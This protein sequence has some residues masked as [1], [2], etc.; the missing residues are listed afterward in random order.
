MMNT[1]N[2]AGIDLVYGRDDEPDMTQKSSL[3]KFDLQ[4]HKRM[5]QWVDDL[6]QSLPYL[7]LRL[8]TAGAY[9][10]KPGYHGK[11]RAF[12]LDGIVME[13]AEG[14]V[15]WQAT[16]YAKPNYRA[17]YLGIQASCLRHFGTVLAWEYN[18]AHHDHI[19]MDDGRDVGFRKSTS[20]VSFLQ[21][22]SMYVYDHPVEIDGIW[23]SE[24]VTAVANMNASGVESSSADQWRH[25]LKY[26][27]MLKAFKT[28]PY[29]PKYNFSRG[30]ER[31]GTEPDRELPP[32][33][34][35]IR[36]V[37]LDELGKIEKSIAR[38]KELWSH[39]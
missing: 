7:M 18:E 9:V 23:G 31:P 13:T 37:L 25:W 33:T 26:S 10:D 17:F 14:A 22:V 21:A 35:P 28:L 6:H 20:I 4:F 3:F 1:R 12:D 8:V 16:D 11:G 5:G 19:H 36:A 29:G 34:P 39:G 38:I 15:F 32:G 27:V 2:I 24:T 30:M